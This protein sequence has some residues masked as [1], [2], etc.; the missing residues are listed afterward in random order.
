MQIFFSAQVNCLTQ[1]VC[2]FPVKSFIMYVHWRLQV[3]T[4]PHT[5]IGFQ[6]IYDVTNHA[7]R[8]TS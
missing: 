1:A 2:Y 6:T 7:C 5:R 8:L 4:F 3:S